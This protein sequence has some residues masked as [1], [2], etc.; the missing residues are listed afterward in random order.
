[1]EQDDMLA[2]ALPDRN[3]ICIELEDKVAAALD[4]A[5]RQGADGAEAG[6]SL[7][8]GLEVTTRMGEVETIEHT[9][10]R[11]VSVT[12]YLGRR[13][14]HASSA[15]LRDSS[16]R[17]CV[18]RAMEIA[19]FTEEDSCNGLADPEQLAVEFPDLDLWHPVPLS[20]GK[21]IERAQ[22]IEAAGR[23]DPRITNSEGANVS[24]SFSVS[25]LGNSIGFMGRSSGTH[26]GQSCVLIAGKGD[27]M[28]RDYWYDSRRSFDDLEDAKE[29]GVQA[30]RRTVQRLG[31]R[32][33]KTCEAPVAFA[34][35]VARSLLGHLL[36]AISGGAL[37]RNASFLK[38]QLG[39]RL[40]PDWLGLA[41]RPHLPREQG[42][43][44]FDD[45]GVAT[46]E[47]EIVSAGVLQGYVLSTYSARRL[48]MET[49]GN[50]GGVHNLR[51][52]AATT[53][54]ADLLA[55]M[56]DGLLVTEVMG[57]GVSMVTGDYSRGA[58]GFWVEKGEIA[59]PVEE[60]TIAGNLRDIWPRIRA[61]GDDLDHRGNIQVGTIW[62]ERMIIAGA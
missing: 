2:Q 31:A 47:R 40:F 6:A 5:R 26:H 24:S 32:K 43:A 13:R 42:S 1:M 7:H 28:Q 15:D 62:V 61:V 14:G 20:P 54:L 50:A 51:V 34:P 33:L 55:G 58:T 8:G 52:L 9:R 46:R 48:G 30:A 23:A 59:Y 27:A 37:Y 16:V 38:D 25:V 19:R 22:E 29:T 21:A 60:V 35:E 3:E 18:D 41:E 10:D 57:Q 45:D 39:V 44:V 36:G 53:P 56:G 4:E 49:T 11:G 17:E 12:V